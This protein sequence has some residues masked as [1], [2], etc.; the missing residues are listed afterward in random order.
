MKHLIYALP[1]A[2]FS[3]AAGAQTETTPATEAD[4]SG[5]TFGT[6]WPLSV[7][8][9]FLTD[10]ESG[11]LR[12]AS[13]LSD[14]WQSLSQEDRDMVTADCTAFLAVHGDADASTDAATA[15]NSDSAAAATG[16]A[17]ASDNSAE[18]AT[19]TGDAAVAG[20]EGSAEVSG[21]GYSLAEMKAICEAV[22]GL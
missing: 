7:G 10:D 19:T 6:S 5:E 20:A 1:L 12:P 11:T 13:E 2:F 17:T 22:E 9:T 3:A 21:A 15:G 14:G 18:A 16:D 8:S 4:A